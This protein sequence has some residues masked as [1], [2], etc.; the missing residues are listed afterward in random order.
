MVYGK[1]IILLKV[2]PKKKI[3]ILSIKDKSCNG[4]EGLPTA[5]F[6]EKR[7]QQIFLYILFQKFSH[8]KRILKK[9]S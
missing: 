4:P 5:N 6:I 2:L 1:L 3:T 8:L 9:E 7:L